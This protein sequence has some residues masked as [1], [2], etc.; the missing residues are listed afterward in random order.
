LK[1][2]GARAVWTPLGVRRDHVVVCDDDHWI[3]EVRPWR[4]GDPSL[5]E[6]LLIPGLI[7]SHVH[8][9][10]SWMRGKVAPGGGFVDWFGRLRNAW[11]EAPS[12][13]VIARLA[14]EQAGRLVTAGTVA[15]ADVANHPGA[16]ERLVRAGLSG[17]AHRE[18]LTMHAPMVDEVAR[19]AALA[20][21]VL[22]DGRSLVVERSSPHALYSTAPAIVRA[23]LGQSVPRSTPATIHLYED[24]GERELIA[25][26]TG[27]YA[28]LLDQLERDWA[29]W[30][31]P[32]TVTHALEEV[33]GIGPHLLLVHGVHLDAKDRKGLEGH[34]VCI[35]I[36]ARSNQWVGGQLPN[37]PELRESGFTL[38][39]G[40]DSLASN[41]DL[42]V[43]NEIPVLGRAFPQVPAAV[44]LD[45]AT[46]GGACALGMPH[47]GAIEV[48][49]AP[50]LVLLSGLNNPEGL[51]E[52]PPSRY[53]LVSPGVP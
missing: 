52:G 53:L 33:D 39:L 44:W 12:R 24:E 38:A 3:Q 34:D 30:E 6:G 45:A 15:V 11:E 40:T 31:P 2:V 10:L 17:V 42:D 48:G 5:A 36:C 43:L 14:D 20:G 37:V 1:R 47:L 41:H 16:P 9:E 19:Q 18:W 35:G 4:K 8:L 13:Q 46:R 23:C 28:A 21:R 25:S 49:R 7:N 29:W 51:L 22:R 32:G 27:P 26:G 50:G